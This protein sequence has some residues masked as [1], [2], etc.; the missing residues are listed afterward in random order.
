M[1]IKSVLGGKSKNLFDVG[2]AD[3][4]IQNDG[5]FYSYVSYTSHF[6]ALSVEAG[7]TYTV[8]CDCYALGGAGIQLQLSCQTGTGY[9]LGTRLFIQLTSE[10]MINAWQHFTG[11]FTVP[12]DVTQVYFSTL[13][14]TKYFRNFQIELGSTATEY[15]PY[16]ITSYKSIMKVSDNFFIA[17]FDERIICNSKDGNKYV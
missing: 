4:T 15:V 12:A 10:K 11:T 2:K 13:Q 17:S 7:K 3:V 14:K 16:E 6:Y 8:S 1:A 5:S 9:T